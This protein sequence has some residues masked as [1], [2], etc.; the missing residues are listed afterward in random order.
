M[1]RFEIDACLPAAS[2]GPDL[3]ELTAS[4]GGLNIDKAEKENKDEK[5]AKSPKD[6]EASPAPKDATA[7]FIPLVKVQSRGTLISQD[8][9]VEVTTRSQKSFEGLNWGDPY[10]QLFFSQTPHLHIALHLRGNFFIINK[11]KLGEGH[12]KDI[13]A[14]Q[15]NGF[16]QLRVLLGI[17]LKKA[18]EA[19]VEERL[20]LLCQR[21]TLTVHENLEGK[22]CLPDDHLAL[23]SAAPQ[24]EEI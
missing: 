16:R 2:K 17:I 4:L 3:D 24:S 12:L 5:D 8:R 10:P 22:S 19:G 18:K 7:D 1:V 6:K 21:G 20:S 9:L 13:H 15:E 11:Y 14:T 23:F